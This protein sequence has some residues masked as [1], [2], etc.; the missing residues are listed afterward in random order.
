MIS[1]W[2][3][4]DEYLLKISCANLIPIFL[5]FTTLLIVD[6]FLIELPKVEFLVFS[7]HRELDM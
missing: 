5:I 6:F 3:Y 1:I 7:K 2:S 4:L